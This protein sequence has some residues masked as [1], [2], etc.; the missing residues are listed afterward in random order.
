MPTTNDVTLGVAFRGV[1]EF[2]GSS[3]TLLVEAP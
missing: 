2:L 1:V 3:A